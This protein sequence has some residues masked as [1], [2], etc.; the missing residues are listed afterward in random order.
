MPEEP[1]YSREIA[2]EIKKFM[3]N[4]EIEDFSKAQ[5]WLTKSDLGV[6]G[7]KKYLIEK[8]V[9]TI[10][11]YLSKGLLQLTIEEIM[12]ESEYRDAIQSKKDHAIVAHLSKKLPPFKVYV[13][14][15]IKSGLMEIKR[16]RYDF[17]AKLSVE[18]KDAKIIFQEN[19]IRSI[20]FGSF[21]ASITLDL[22]RGDHDVKIGSMER[23]LS[24]TE[25]ITIDFL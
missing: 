16:I 9:E 7:A 20:S 5:E 18:V 8:I 6:D 19:K 12:N 15:V 10:S 11:Q 1:L 22:L 21:I 3:D 24:L 4:W 17:K 13:E 2:Q 23:S 14:F 25:P